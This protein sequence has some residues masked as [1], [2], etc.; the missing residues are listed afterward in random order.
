MRTE[1]GI[2]M[3]GM[4][5]QYHTEQIPIDPGGNELDPDWKFVDHEG[6]GHFYGD[7]K[8]GDRYPTLKWVSRPCTMGHGDD[9]DSEGYWECRQCGEVIQPGTRPYSGPT[10]VD[11]PTTVEVTIHSDHTTERW[12]GDKSWFE[13]AWDDA[14]D[15]LREGLG[16]PASIEVRHDRG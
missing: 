15:A 10:F 14:M 8:S 5:V 4:T 13:D 2:P 9:C 12:V 7:F 16:H 11:G 3:S 1:F 6:H